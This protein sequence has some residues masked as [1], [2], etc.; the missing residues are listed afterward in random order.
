VNGDNNF[1]YNL[2]IPSVVKD[3]MVEQ[4]CQDDSG[5]L[6]IFVILVKHISKV[7]L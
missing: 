3:L 7:L 6:E 4:I 5:T 2:V 1:F